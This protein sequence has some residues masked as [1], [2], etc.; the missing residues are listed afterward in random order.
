MGGLVKHNFVASLRKI[1]NSGAL[2]SVI[3]FKA[4]PLLRTDTLAR[5]WG[6]FWID[7]RSRFQLEQTLKQNVAKIGEVDLNH[8]AALSWLANQVEPWLLI[9]DNADDAA[10]DLMEYLPKG[11]RGY[12]LITTR[13]PGFQ[14]IGNL[15]PSHF[16]FDGLKKEEAYSLLVRTA[17]LKDAITD[18]LKWIAEKI[19]DALGYLALAIAVAGSAI[20]EGYCRIQNYL[21][22]FENLWQE[23]GQI[24]ARDQSTD[25][26][27]KKRFVLLYIEC[28][29][30]S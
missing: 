2:T 11:G 23:R 1:T 6:V 18:E 14:S 26:F 8:K 28:Y 12:V 10:I 29:S 22:Y 21:Q 24:K 4:S 3:I 9:I 7:G 25:D 15:D 17:G 19:V 20:R 30:Q 27:E 5:F 13:N 16:K